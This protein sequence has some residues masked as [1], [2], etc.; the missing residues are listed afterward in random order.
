MVTIFIFLVMIGIGLMFG[1]LLALANNKLAVEVD[2]RVYAVD[3]VLPKGQCGACGYAGCLGY[4]DAVVKNPDVPVN[5]C[6]P[7]K[8]DVARKIAEITGKNEAAVD[9]RIASV[10]CAWTIDKAVQNFEYDGIHGCVSANLLQGGNKV[11][12]YGCLGFGTCVKAC[13]FNAMRMSPEGLPIINPEKCNGCGKCVEA[14]PRNIIELIDP[15]SMVRVNCMSLDKPAVSRQNCKVSCIG[16]GLCA[17]DCPLE[18]IV[19]ENNLAV[20]D[21]RI[22]IE[23]CYNPT[24]LE[25][26][27]TKA[28]R[29]VIF[30]ILPGTENENSDNFIYKGYEQSGIYYF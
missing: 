12:K 2:P 17:K 30:G 24:C 4:A 7:G 20:V 8:L 9:S 10:R 28:I 11:C 18:A 15:E 21:K 14:C 26:C 29:P 22:C 23:E 5:L 16:C 25:H 27:P 6:A 13:H 3:D 1:I 19:I